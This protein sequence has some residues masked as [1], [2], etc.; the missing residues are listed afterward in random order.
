MSE[1]RFEERIA[2]F[3]RAR[4]LVLGDAML[5]RYVYG[6]IARIS[7]E[8]PV[9]ILSAE[10]ETAMP[11]GAANVARAV[12]ALGG[13]AVLIGLVGEDAAGR[14]LIGLLEALAGV[15]CGLV[16]AAGRPTTVKVRYVA[17]RQQVVRVD[18]EVR[19]PP[20]P[21]GEALLAQ[22]AARLPG[23]D[24]VVLSDYAKGVLAPEVVRAA[25]A[26]AKAAGKPVLVDPKS[27]D[28]AR[29]DGADILTPNTGEAAAATGLAGRDDAAVAAMAAAMLAVAPGI[30][31][32]LVTR[33]ERGMTLAERGGGVRHLP[34]AAREVADVSGAGDTV[35]ATL[36]LALAAGADP[37][38]AAQLANAAA[39][40][41]VGK[42]GTAEVTPDELRQ[43]LNSAQ[44]ETIATKTVGWERAEAIVRTWRQ[45]G[46]AVG[47]TNGCF[48]LVHPGHVSLI[49][50]AKRACDRLVVGLNTDA[51]VRRL[52]GPSRP[53]QNEAAR[54]LVMGAMAAV[55]LV[56]LFDEDTPR[57]L[58]ERLR[59][60]VLVKGADYRAD[61]VV[62]ADFVQG[63]GG[64]LVLAELVAGQ[65]TTGLLSRRDG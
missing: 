40:I 15:E 9:P 62:G 59:P 14:Q 45:Q 31:A 64:R 17:E 43:A 65:S 56:V 2:A 47:F 61:Q 22:F 3:S 6:T 44:L 30:G 51:S 26:M 35:V 10:R 55:D 39:G 36:A 24:I 37:F 53:V 29:Y 1:S 7:P 32:V 33:G 19:D 23:A 63:Y 42:L 12:A 38:A 41:A 28:I 54:A 46:L 8:A 21:A 20:G 11:G 49:A 27:T 48:D 25:I 5:D 57:E 50:Q 52:K 16:T 13:R 58:I 18:Y 60:D 34:V 4:V